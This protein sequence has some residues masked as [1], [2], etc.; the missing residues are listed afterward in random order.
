MRYGGALAGVAL[1][2]V[3]GVAGWQGWRWHQQQQAGQ[4]AMAFMEV[5][6]AA[7]APGA[8][9]KATAERFAAI[10]QDAPEGYR[11]LARLRTAALKAE[12][13][14]R[15][16]ALAIWD[17]VASDS[18]APQVYRDLASLM[19]AL[20]GL[21]TQDPAALESR[22]APL[23]GGAWAASARELQA[24]VAI[25]RG[26]ATEAKRT[27]KPWRRMSP[28]RRG[29][30]TR[31]PRGR[32]I[33]ELSGMRQMVW[34][35]RAALLGAAGLLAGCETLDDIF[36][37]PRSRCSVS[38]APCWRRAG[39]WRPT[40]PWP[41]PHGP[42]AARGPRRLAAGGRQCRPCAGEPGAAGLADPRLD[43]LGGQ[44]QQLPQPH[45]R[46][47]GGGGRHGLRLRRLR[48]RLGLRPRQRWAP[49]ALRHQAQEGRC[50]RRRRRL[51]L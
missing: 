4:A 11:V 3:V 42:A 1:L 37:D 19:W 44:R 51:R 9:L 28:R 22:L 48:R 12:T 41:T 36:G 47:A 34:T 15:D 45:H 10:A 38:A 8:D 16:A 31:G 46:R 49:L 23:T 17:Q 20:H 6:R 35:R 39:T 13:G 26:E 30:G 21:E 18:R 5:H 40:R 43:G 33:G 7:E 32:G 29:A 2:A 50:R 24:L 14:E 27:W 25:R